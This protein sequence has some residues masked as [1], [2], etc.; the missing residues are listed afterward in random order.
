MNMNTRDEKI[1]AVLAQA[2]DAILQAIG[3]EDGLDGATGSNVLKKILSLY[4]TPFP[5]VK[6]GEI[7]GCPFTGS[8]NFTEC[9]LD[10][11]LKIGGRGFEL[12]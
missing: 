8:H 6:H 2:Y 11:P 12:K 9:G 3:N 10:I 5:M 1:K 4:K 7:E